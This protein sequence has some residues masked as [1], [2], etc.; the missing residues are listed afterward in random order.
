VLVVLC[1]ATGCGYRRKRRRMEGRWREVMK[2]GCVIHLVK[3]CAL[4][5]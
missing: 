5:L 2:W 4:V 1:A 3:G